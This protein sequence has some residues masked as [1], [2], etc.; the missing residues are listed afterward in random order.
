[1]ATGTSLLILSAAHALPASTAAPGIINNA[2]VRVFDGGSNETAVFE[3]ILPQSYNGGGIDVIAHLAMASGET[4]GDVDID[5]AF[6][7]V[8][9]ATDSYGSTQSNDGTAVPGTA[10]DT[11]KVTVPNTDGAQIDSIATGDL[12]RVKVTRDAASD[13]NNGEMHLLALALRES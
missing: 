1:M 11:F 4:T 9:N 6:A 12:F 13:V 5:V 8:T 2:E 7:K 3:A 10:Q